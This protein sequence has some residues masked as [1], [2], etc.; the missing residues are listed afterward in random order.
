MIRELAQNKKFAQDEVGLSS[1]RIPKSNF[2]IL[3]KARKK[4]IFKFSRKIKKIRNNV[5]KK[6]TNVTHFTSFFQPQ[7]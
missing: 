1:K 2:G 4:G 7:I 5:T 3:S 6:L